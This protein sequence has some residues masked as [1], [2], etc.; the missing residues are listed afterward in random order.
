LIP[1]LSREQTRAFDRLAIDGCAVPSVVLMENAGRGAAEIIERLSDERPGPV[2]VV[3]GPGNNG[4][5]GFVVARRLLTRGKRVRV[6]L[7]AGP[8]RIAGDARLEY[9]AW[10]GLGGAVVPISEKEIDRLT[11]ELGKARVVVDAMLGTGLDRD[12]TGFFAS[13]IER[14][15]QCAALRVALD[16]PSGLD[17]NTGMPLGIAVRAAH[18]VTFAHHKLGLW[19]STGAEYAGRVTR[20]DIG[21]P[22]ELVERV[23]ES[24]RIL[25]RADVMSWLVPRPLSAHKGSAG[26]VVVVAGSPGKTGAA[27]LSARGALR[28]GAG[29]VT[30][31]T[32]PRAAEALDARVLEEMT[33]RID[34]ANVEASLDDAL[35]SADAVVVGPGLGLG[36]ESK[37]IVD[38]IVLRA[39][40]VK[41]VDAD[42]LTLLG[43]R[44]AELRSA[45]GSAILTPHPGEMAR[46][47]GASTEDVEADRFGAVARAVS[48]SGSVVL[49]KGARTLV[50][51]PAEKTVANPSGTPALATAGSGD[52]LSGIT[53]AFAALSERPFQAACAAAYVHGASGEHWVQAHGADRGLLAHEIADSVPAVLAGLARDRT[54]L[55]V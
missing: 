28:A 42:A 8:D 49:L 25:E 54:A 46:L 37:R 22:P 2:A 47:L 3:C 7:T 1:L 19:T 18:T 45:A 21:V 34:P 10:V 51:A 12:V 40:C 30:L 33:A 20:V 31:C 29:L 14:M 26:R 48:L 27:L 6:L 55:P 50:G 24:G 44:L 16:I 9:D 39:K 41:I 36:P 17:S 35:R 43:G 11:D 13:V 5:D 52:V 15:N 4:G 32:V 38:H 23:G 53:A